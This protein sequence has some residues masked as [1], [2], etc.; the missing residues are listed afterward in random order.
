[1]SKTKHEATA[2]WLGAN[3]GDRLIGIEH[4]NQDLIIEISEL[5]EE[6]G[7]VKGEFKV[8]KIGNWKGA[9][10]LKDLEDNNFTANDFIEKVRDRLGNP[11]ITWLVNINGFKKMKI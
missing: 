5:Q 1:M 10:K 2:Y 7:P 3:V 8:I 4:R 9:E 11:K 6:G